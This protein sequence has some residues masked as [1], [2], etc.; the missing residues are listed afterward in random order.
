MHRAFE[1]ALNAPV[2]SQLKKTAH[3]LHQMQPDALG[4]VGLAEP[5]TNHLGRLVAAN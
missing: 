1:Q 4:V 2:V 5:G 3:H